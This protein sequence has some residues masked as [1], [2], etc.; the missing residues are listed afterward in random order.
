MSSEG[1]K[2]C[3]ICELVFKD[4]TNKALY[5]Y[6][7]KASNNSKTLEEVK[8]IYEICG[9]LPE[10]FAH[11]VVCR[12]LKENDELETVIDLFN[13]FCES[14][15]IPIDINAIML[16]ALEYVDKKHQN[17]I[18]SSLEVFNGEI[19]YAYLN[20]NEKPIFPHNENG[21]SFVDT[22]CYCSDDALFVGSVAKKMKAIEPDNTIMIDPELLKT[23][24]YIG[25]YNGRAISAEEAFSR[26]VKSIIITRDYNKLVITLPAYFNYTTAFPIIRAVHNSGVEIVDVISHAHAIVEYI[27]RD[28]E[29]QLRREE[30]IIIVNICKKS[31]YIDL[32]H[33]KYGELIIC[34]SY[35]Y[36]GGYSEVNE[37][38][39]SYLVWER[40]DH[41]DSLRFFAGLGIEEALYKADKIRKKLV[42]NDDLTVQ[43]F[44]IVDGLP[45]RITITREV[46]SDVCNDYI[47]QLL[48]SLESTLSE[49]KLE[50]RINSK[51]VIV[52]NGVEALLLQKI[53]QNKKFDAFYYSDEIIAE[54]AL[55]VNR[56]I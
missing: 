9:Y 43:L 33:W 13:R 16:Y 11:E 17:V 12:L 1:S 22:Y 25:H 14:Q 50:E 40:N 27:E 28:K 21:E 54:G 10:V 20:Y 26:I 31:V 38:I 34:K 44:S 24:G 30:K 6:Y 52:G 18:R 56:N 8:T 46:L 36:S 42:I 19:R 53:L 29:F 45:R 23:Q 37:L 32:V 55:L 39:A 49:V 35:E 5:D 7:L 47:T 41:A 51:V 2:L 48:S 4:E 3:A 15:C